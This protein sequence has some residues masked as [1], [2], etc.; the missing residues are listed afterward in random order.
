MQFHLKQNLFSYENYLALLTANNE[1]KSYNNP[2]NLLRLITSL[3]EQ[4]YNLFL[5]I[6]IMAWR[7]YQSFENIKETLD[8]VLHTI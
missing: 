7:G 1:T 4:K 5:N 2:Q 8:T 3:K 6:W